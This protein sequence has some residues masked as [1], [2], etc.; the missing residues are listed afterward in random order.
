MSDIDSNMDPEIIAGFLDEAP[1]YVSV[2][3]E[4]LLTLE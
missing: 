2:L 1:G 3:D 4:G